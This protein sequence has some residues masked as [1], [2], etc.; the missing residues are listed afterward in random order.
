MS[1]NITE[2]V[3]AKVRQPR[4]ISPFWLLPLVAFIIGSLLFFQILKERGEDI[5]IR[6]HDGAGITAGKTT[7][8]YQG[9]QIG[10]VKKVS[11]TDGLKEVEV[12]A[13]I[14][15]E[16]KSVLRSETKFWLVRP[17]A[18]LAGI[19]GLDTLV[20]GNYITLLPGEGSSE[21]EFIA[22][23]EPPLVPLNEGDL[24]VKLLADDLG[25]IAVGA[26]VYFRKVPVGTVADYRFTKDQK[27]VE[28]ELIIDKKY[29]NLVKQDSHFW[30]ISG[31]KADLN[32]ATGLSIQMDS[33]LSVVQ[34]AVAFDSPE[35]SEQANQG[36]EYTL[37][38]DLKAA[39]R[40]IEVDITL[41][42]MT[43][44]QANETGVFYQGIQIGILSQ[45][46][47]PFEGQKELKGTT[48]IKGKLLIDPNYQ[49]LL[50]TN[51]VIV[52]KQPKFSLN[53]EQLTKL[54]EVFRGNY[55]ELI[56]GDGEPSK[57][58]VV[59]RNDDFLL[60]RADT[61]TFTL[62]APQSYGVDQ[63][64]G[65]YYHD[66]QIGELLKRDVTVENVTFTAIIFPEY[67]H[68]IG[69]QSK[70]VAISNL[71][72]SI[73]LDGMRI[74]AGSPTSWLQGGI[75]LLDGKPNG[76]I[77]AQYPLYKDLESAESG[78]I[79]SE[80]KATLSLSAMELSGIDKGSVIL[81][82]KFPIGEVLAIRPQK[83]RFDVDLF[84]EPKYRHLISEHSRFWI[85]PA[86]KVDLSTN[87]LSLQADP[88]LRTLKG[89]ISFDNNGAKNNRILYESFD[90][91]RSGNT[92]V[93]LVA[94]DASKLSE[95]MPI[96]YMGLTIGKVETLKLE[97]AKKQVKV[98]AFI[99]GQYFNTV[100]KAG[101][102]FKAISPEVSTTG[103]KNLD[104]ALQNYIAVEV[105][106]GGK[107]TEFTLA[108]TDT[109]STQY[110][111]GFPIIVE[112]TDA[113]GIT[114]DAPV[115]YRGMQVGIV[116][117]LSLSELGDRVLIHLQISS[118]Y[119][120]LVRKNSQFWTASGYT[121]DISLSGAS[122]NSGTMS[123]LLNGGIAFS[124]PS[125]KVVQPQAEANRRF[126]LQRKTPEDALGWDQGVAE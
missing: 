46:D 100:A 115:L 20:S 126:R 81:Y 49:E 120:H 51:S 7:I 5:T 102:Q 54:G 15:P 86:V 16:A 105:G 97:N 95:G 60:N 118:Q 29:A 33:L 28:I 13:E 61:T 110:S 21:D 55:F 2:A 19:S 124:T 101:S 6:F 56:S 1:N 65:I 31:I 35:H 14:N 90:K 48:D 109:L 4:K 80:K 103:F 89:A 99:D 73:G 18:S 43:A 104:A 47:S 116:K 78:L 9:L 57:Q 123:Q 114:P 32:M 87:G 72:V 3:P 30:N 38:S 84:I 108:D 66:V 68:L 59:Q 82:R 117:R 12:T 64:Q 83:S 112:T 91:A 76:K 58:F 17:T 121:M 96:K 53:K 125:G 111:N 24:M 37:Y 23:N 62:T 93:T 92:Y 70:F 85:E 98:T 67:R 34:G 74:H 63:G 52:L 88:L 94:K 106:S 69:Q 39:K 79:S 11:F 119:S 77:Q 22:E 44:V 36:Q 25:S 71:D 40:G 26:S 27:K 75:R 107:K 8:R 122:I 42:A 41:P 113:N 50:R 45:L 10:L